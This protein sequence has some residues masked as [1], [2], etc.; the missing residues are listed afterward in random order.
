MAWWKICI[1]KNNN[2]DCEENTEPFDVTNNQGYYEFNW[3]ATWTYKILEIPHQNW[4][5]TNPTSKYYTITLT[6]WQKVTNKN[7]GNLKT[8]GK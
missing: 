2:W 6:S 8:K 5:V 4:S 7:F 3:L 1:D